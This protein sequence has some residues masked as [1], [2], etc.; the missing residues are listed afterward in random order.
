MFLLFT[1]FESKMAKNNTFHPKLIIVDHFDD[2]KNQIDLQIES[3]LDQKTK[4]KSL[5]DEESNVL[6]KLRQSQLYIIDK[7]QE[8]NLS[9]LKYD[10]DEFKTKWNHV[11]SN[12]VLTFEEKIELLKEELISNDCILIEDKAY[13]SGIS[14]W[15]TRWFFNRKSLEFLRYVYFFC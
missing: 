14:V 9:H 1:R 7:V 11:I 13:T 6:N 5:S 2:I 3:L 12:V 10:E 8:K 15:V 4:D